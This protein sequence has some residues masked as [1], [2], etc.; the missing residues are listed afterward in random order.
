M[1]GRGETGGEVRAWTFDTALMLTS[2]MRSAGLTSVSFYVD[3]NVPLTKTEEDGSTSEVA[4][5]NI[6]GRIVFHPD[7]LRQLEDSIRQRE[8][9]EARWLDDGGAP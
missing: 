4:F 8:T 6:A 5:W 2:T 1:A 9:A 7:R 3:A